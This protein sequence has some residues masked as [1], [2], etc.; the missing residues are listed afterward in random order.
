MAY[1][2]ICKDYEYERDFKIRTESESEFVQK[3]KQFMEEEH[4]IDLP[5]EQI[6]QM[7]KL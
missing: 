6:I 7:G 4:G 2:V 5:K 3:V 1:R